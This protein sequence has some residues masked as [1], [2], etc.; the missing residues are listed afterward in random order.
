MV[1]IRTYLLG[2]ETIQVI[3]SVI[4]P[5]IRSLTCGFISLEIGQFIAEQLGL[6]LPAVTELL[7]DKKN[8]DWL[9][10]EVGRD[11]VEV[12]RLHFQGLLYN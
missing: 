10:N 1:L 6:D 8:E 12:R 7:N 3:F 2:T 4:E 5:Y 11:K 9:V